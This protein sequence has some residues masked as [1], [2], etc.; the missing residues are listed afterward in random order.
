[1]RSIWKH[2]VE[3]VIK[4]TW[5]WICFYSM[6]S[7]K[8]KKVY[9]SNSLF[10]K[11]NMRINLK[12]FQCNNKGTLFMKHWNHKSYVWQTYSSLELFFFAGRGYSN[13][14]L[15]I[16]L[17]RAHCTPNSLMTICFFK[18]RLMVIYIYETATLSLS[19]TRHAFSSQ[20]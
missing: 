20:K 8:C 19:F 3:L 17:L 16:V 12:R 15:T 10:I 5:N 9:L 2:C 11:N 13:R 1:M 7:V 6:V 14:I 4:S 18:I